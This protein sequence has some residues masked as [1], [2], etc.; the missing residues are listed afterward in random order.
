[1]GACFHYCFCNHSRARHK[2]YQEGEKIVRTGCT[3]CECHK[4][5][6]KETRDWKWQGF[7]SERDYVAFIKRRWRSDNPEHIKEYQDKWNLTRAAYKINWEKERPRTPE[8]LKKLRAR[9]IAKTIPIPSGEICAYC[10]SAATQRH[11]PDYSM[12][13]SVV[14][15]CAR[16]NK[17]IEYGRVGGA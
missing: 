1:M 8:V 10:E 15:C 6:H 7:K 9:W 16:C 14:F 2:R 4:Y 3:Q 17:N 5:N 11:H 13:R 12:P